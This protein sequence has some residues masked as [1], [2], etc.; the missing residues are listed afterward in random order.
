MRVIFNLFVCR[1]YSKGMKM[2]L[3]SFDD[4][5]IKLERCKV[6]DMY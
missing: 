2:V 4:K 6:V 1:C 3:V 5:K